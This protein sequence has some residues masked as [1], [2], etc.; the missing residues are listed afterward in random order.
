MKGFPK[1]SLQAA[2]TGSVVELPPPPPETGPLPRAPSLA[3]S[4]LDGAED[5]FCFLGNPAQKR[6]AGQRPV[7]PRKGASCSDP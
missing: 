4:V 5:S 6:Q 1:L 7:G 2:G 3:L